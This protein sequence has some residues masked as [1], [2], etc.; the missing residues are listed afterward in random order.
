ME[1]NS[2]P[3]YTLKLN[4]RLKRWE[5]TNQQ[6]EVIRH[7]PSKEVA[8]AGRKIE[9]AVEGGILHIYKENGELGVSRT[10]KR[11]GNKK[12]MKVKRKVTALP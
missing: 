8:L 10:F 7:F 1:E 11:G 3:V 12:G 4:P 9:S 5:L 2:V 6:D